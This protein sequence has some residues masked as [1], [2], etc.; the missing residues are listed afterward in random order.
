MNWRGGMFP[1]S[2][3]SLIL[4]NPWVQCLEER[5][6]DRTKIKERVVLRLF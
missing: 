1:L 4:R 2:C 6:G 3:L 5:I